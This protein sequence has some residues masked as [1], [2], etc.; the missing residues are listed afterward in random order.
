MLKQHNKFSSEYNTEIKRLSLI[1]KDDKSKQLEKLL[2][3]HTELEKDYQ[4]KST[5]ITKSSNER[6]QLLNIASYTREIEK[7]ELRLNTNSTTHNPRMKNFLGTDRNNYHL[8]PKLSNIQTPLEVSQFIFELLKD[9]IPPNGIIFDPFGSDISTEVF[10]FNSSEHPR[11]GGVD[12]LL[13]EKAKVNKEFKPALILCNPPFNDIPI[14]L[15]VPMGFRANLTL[16]SK[17]KMKFET[18]EYPPIGLFIK[19]KE[20][21]LKQQITILKRQVYILSSKFRQCEK[22]DE[23][24]EY[25]QRYLATKTECHDCAGEKLIAREKET[26]QHA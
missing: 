11:R 6:K 17:R 5:E 25:T 3:E 12:F 10:W 7:E 9:K 20:Q 8:K 24:P 22:H 16:T 21:E 26:T 15:F 18:G 2:T 19:K 14:V 1:L 13:A 4:T 23:D